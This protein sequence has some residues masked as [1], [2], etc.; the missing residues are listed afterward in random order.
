M[1]GARSEEASSVSW[2]LFVRWEDGFQE[3]RDALC[4]PHP[5]RESHTSCWNGLDVNYVTF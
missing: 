5:G 4:A 3:Q 2:W 1:S